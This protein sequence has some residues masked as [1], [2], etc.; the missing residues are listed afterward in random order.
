[1]ILKNKIW[2]VVRQSVDVLAWSTNL[3]VSAVYVFRTTK[4]LKENK[5]QIQIHYS[6]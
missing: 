5:V 2:S 6:C 1:M 3:R 4:P